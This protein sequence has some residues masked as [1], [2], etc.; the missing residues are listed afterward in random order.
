MAANQTL[1]LKILGDFGLDGRA[2]REMTPMVLEK[3]TSVGIERED[4]VRAV[5]ARI[6]AQYHHSIKGLNIETDCVENPTVRYRQYLA[7]LPGPR[8]D[9]TPDSGTDKSEPQTD[10]GKDISAYVRGGKGKYSNLT[11]TQLRDEHAKF[12]AKKLHY[13][14][15]AYIHGMGALQYEIA[16]R[17]KRCHGSAAFIR[18]S[19]EERVAEQDRPKDRVERTLAASKADLSN[20]DAVVAEITR[21]REGEGLPRGY[22]LNLRENLFIGYLQRLAESEVTRTKFR[23]SYQAEA[24]AAKK[25]GINYR[26]YFPDRKGQRESKTKEPPRKKQTKTTR[27]YQRRAKATF[28]LGDDKVVVTKGRLAGYTVADLKRLYD[29]RY[30][31]KTGGQLYAMRDSRAGALYAATGR[32]VRAGVIPSYDTIITGKSVP[33][34][35]ENA[36]SETTSSSDPYNQLI[37]DG[38]DHILERRARIEYEKMDEQSFIALGLVRYSGLKREEIEQRDPA[39]YGVALQREVLEGLIQEGEVIERLLHPSGRGTK[40]KDK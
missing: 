26:I 38:V 16:Q 40:K 22:F 15:P 35:R 39:Y 30:A 33:G 28:P 7:S 29:E 32:L 12:L 23:Q 13:Q 34:A 10:P 25:R 5:A 18:G 6:C 21:Y 4:E 27:R 17:E 1:I 36:K 24:E 11:N 9:A 3:V 8:Q 31:G 37:A 20:V 2:I 19:L 14:D